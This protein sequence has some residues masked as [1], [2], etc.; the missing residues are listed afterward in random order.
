VSLAK[1][2]T[3]GAGRFRISGPLTFPTVRLVLLASEAQFKDAAQ[4]EID[5]STVDA[6]D[7]AGLALLIEWYR[8]AARDK[9][10][11]RFVGVPVQL[12]ALAKMSDLT[13]MMT[14]GDPA[15]APN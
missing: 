10:S 13:W 11:I 6:T 12:L 8:C 14:P 2:E 15:V 3:L 1:V 7:S 4:L 5:L 9:K